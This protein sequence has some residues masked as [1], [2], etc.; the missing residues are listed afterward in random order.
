SIYLFTSASNEP[1]LSWDFDEPVNAAYISHYGDYVVA[2]TE[3]GQVYFFRA[4]QESLEWQC[5]CDSAVLSISISPF[6]QFALI[7]CADGSVYLYNI[8]QQALIWKKSLG[9]SIGSVFVRSSATESMALDATET[10]H[11][12]GGD[13]EEINTI[14]GVDVSSMPYWSEFFLYSK[15]GM[16]NLQRE[17]SATADWNYF[18]SEE[19]RY[20]DSNYGSSTVMLTYKDNM[21]FFFED[22]LMI[23]GSR[24]LWAMLSLLVVVQSAMVF[25]MFYLQ[26]SSFYQ[27]INNREFLEFFVG[28]LFGM[29][30][31][32]VLAR[33]TDID[34]MN[35]TIGAI[36]AGLASWQLSKV[37]GAL[38]GSFLGYITGLFG[39]FAIGGAF[40][41]YHWMGGAE[42]D[43][44]SSFFGTAFYGGL[45]G[46][47][48]SIV[49]IVVGLVIKDYFD[50]YR[51]KR[52]SSKV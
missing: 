30:A 21:K 26:K 38:V 44:I 12:F 20:I 16:F 10:L 22:Q 48:Y 14:D 19:L 18:D 49:G 5:T 23:L 25:Y 32:V 52:R 37:E 33:G 6:A 4:F 7:G 17:D 11:L 15:D 41:L 46:A 51:R 43:I 28:A 2:G 34:Y 40:G 1:V 36:S 8:E 27:V 35:L 29:L 3:S 42:Q 31:V 24:K 47:F 50:E 13:G 9:A 39:S 45:L